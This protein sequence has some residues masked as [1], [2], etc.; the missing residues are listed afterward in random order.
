MVQNRRNGWA[1]F[2]DKG[3]KKF[4]EYPCKG[5]LA[6]K[7]KTHSNHKRQSDIAKNGNTRFKQRYIILYYLQ[8]I[9]LNSLLICIVLP[10][11]F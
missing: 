5:C 3:M 9:Y 10:L 7:N 8:M 2:S 1:D 6:A 11:F 4:F